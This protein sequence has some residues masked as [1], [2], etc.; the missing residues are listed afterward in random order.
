M[1]IR[2]L[3]VG[4]WARYVEIKWRLADVGAGMGCP[5]NI[6]GGDQVNVSFSTYGLWCV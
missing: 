6:Q 3:V 1:V 4:Q 5:W 2:L